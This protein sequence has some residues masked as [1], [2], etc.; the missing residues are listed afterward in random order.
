MRVYSPGIGQYFVLPKY[1]RN[2]V[3]TVQAGGQATADP[4]VVPVRPENALTDML[5]ASLTV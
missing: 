3:E 4:A 5:G 2:V 1:W